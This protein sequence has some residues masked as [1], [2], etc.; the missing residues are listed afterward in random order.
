MQEHPTQGQTINHGKYISR[1][2]WRYVKNFLQYEAKTLPSFDKSICFNYFK[3]AFAPSNPNEIFSIPH[4]IPSFSPPQ[5]SF[6]RRLPTYRNITSVIRKMKSSSSP[7][8]KDQISVVCFKRCPYLRSYIAEIIHSVWSSGR[9]PTEWRKAC[10]ILIHKKGDASDKANFRPITLE[11]VALK[12]FTCS[13]RNSIFKSLADNKYIEHSIQQGFSP[14]LSGT[15]EHTAH[16]ANI[17]NKARINTL[18]SSHY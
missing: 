5:L 11:T 1:N 14:K 8:P 7:C 16:R 10:T 3:T 17:V 12:I 2:F 15:L 6:T 18:W 13:L 9:I 4:W